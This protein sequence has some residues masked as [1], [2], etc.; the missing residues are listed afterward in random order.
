MREK[1][2][3]HYK[4]ILKHEI[5]LFL[6]LVC[7]FVSPEFPVCSCV[8]CFKTGNLLL[9]STLAYAHIRT[10][11]LE[12]FNIYFH[13]KKGQRWNHW[14]FNFSPPFFSSFPLPFLSNSEEHLQKGKVSISEWKAKKA[15]KIVLI[16]QPVQ[17]WCAKL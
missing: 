13:W 7:L 10:D 6:F 11:Q 17:L 14:K 9:W 5:W 3:L 1:N 8:F 16:F 2:I 15:T 12:C 4:R